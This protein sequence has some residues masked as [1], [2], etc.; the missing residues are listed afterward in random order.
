MT[1]AGREIEQPLAFEAIEE[2]D[3]RATNNVVQ[4]SSLP[5]PV[6]ILSRECRVFRPGSF[7]NSPAI[8]RRGEEQTNHPSRRD[9]R[10]STAGYRLHRL[11]GTHD[12]RRDESKQEARRTGLTV[13]ETGAFS[14]RRET[15]GRLPL[16][17]NG[18]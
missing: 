12:F 7:D 13:R 4:S 3:A 2:Q 8:Y 9:N 16:R 1:D 5:M 10:K 14:T 11:N 6:V 15:P 17:R 18:A